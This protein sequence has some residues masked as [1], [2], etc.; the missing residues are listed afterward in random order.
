LIGAAIKIILDVSDDAQYIAFGVLLS[1]QGRIWIDD[2]KFEVVDESIPVTSG[3]MGDVYLDEPVNLEI[4]QPRC[5]QPDAAIRIRYAGS[6]PAL[7]L[8]LTEEP[9]G[10]GEDHG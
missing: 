4:P 9:D 8:V 3:V 5:A 6:V 7:A 1:G 2:V 10:L